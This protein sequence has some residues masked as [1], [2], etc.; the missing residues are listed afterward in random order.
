MNTVSQVP[1][2]DA[3]LCKVQ[4]QSMTTRSEVVNR[5]PFE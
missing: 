2:F 1:F 3:E 5:T 4:D